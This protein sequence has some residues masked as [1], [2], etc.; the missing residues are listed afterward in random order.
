M[1]AAIEGRAPA[2]RL[3]DGTHPGRVRLQITAFD[4]SAEYY[5]DILGLD[6]HRTDDGS[7]ALSPRESNVTL[8][9]LV[10]N[11]DARP[12]PRGGRLG[13]YH[14]A[15][16]LPSRQLLGRFIRHLAARHV[17]FSAA[18]H[19]VSEALYLWDPDGLGIEVYVDR[20]RDRWRRRDG[21]LIMTTE[22]LDLASLADPAGPEPWGGM[23]PGTTIGHVHLSVGDLDTARALYHSGLGLDETV[24][25]YPGAL[26]LSAG[27]YHH[28]LGLNTWS[29]GA[30]TAGP[31]DARLLE[32]ELVVP[33][34]ADARRAA[35][36]LE[37]AGYDVQSDHDDRVVSDP[38][39]TRLRIRAV[40][41]LDRP[42][43]ST[44][45]A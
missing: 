32:W 1:G 8:V 5:R 13:L 10:E 45:L 11:Q 38:W 14:F 22:P 19:F 25:S 7:I 29:A 30:R 43:R 40:E 36:S 27:G 35:V 31:D 34:A 9:E 37:A 33:D 41:R 24:W 16:L 6:T 20:P 18:D 44:R 39:G 12:V 15:L 4:R 42:R 28:H 23:P 26:F 21:E 2:H 17:K 3:P